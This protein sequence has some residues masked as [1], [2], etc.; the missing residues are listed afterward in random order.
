MDLVWVG[1][2]RESP[3]GTLAITS[4]SYDWDVWERRG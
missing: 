3:E 2:L 4:N 1:I